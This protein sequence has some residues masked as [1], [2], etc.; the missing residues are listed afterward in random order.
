MKIS[1]I[2]LVS[3]L[4]LLFAGC[5][6]YQVGSTLPENVQS[7]SLNIVNRTDEP[8][9]EVAVMKALRAEVQM[10]GRLQLA[11]PGEGDAILKVTINRFNLN[12]L[13]FDQRRGS[14]AR[15]YRMVLD[16]SSVL[17]RTESGEV[18]LE[19]PELVGESEFPY[20]ADLTTAKL[21]ALPEAAS[22]LA[23]KVVSLVTTA[24]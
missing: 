11:A 20:A 23:R 24:W 3:L 12:A 18:I 13:A 1:N 16:A 7:V 2:L 9:I 4:G 21:G 5:A 17:S 14:L 6:G 19:N 10:D 15:E 22:D 8:S